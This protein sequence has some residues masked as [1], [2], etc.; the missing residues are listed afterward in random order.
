MHPE[1]LHSAG[2]VDPSDAIRVRK[3]DPFR[4]AA[5]PPRAYPWPT[6]GVVAA[7]LIWPALWNGYPLV[8]ADS[9]TYLGQA[10]LVYASWDRPPFYSLFLYALHWRLSLWPAVVGQGVLLAHL[11]FL[12]F[13]VEGQAASLQLAAAAVALATLTG[14]PFIAAQLQPDLFTGCVVL[15]TWLLGFRYSALSLNERVYLLMLATFSIVVHQ[16]H[17]PLAFGLI[18][19][20]LPLRGA[21]E[22]LREAMQS[23]GRMLAPP[24]LAILGLIA[25]NTAAHKVPM[26]SPYGSVFLATRLLFDPAGANYLARHCPEAS[27]RVCDVRGAMGQGHNDF[28]WDLN[29]PLYTHLGGPKGWAAEASNLVRAI[30]ADDPLGVARD[31]WRNTLSQLAHANT[32]EGLG[33]WPAAPGPEPLIHRFFPGE[34]GAFREAK[35]QRGEL[36]P[37][38]RR[39]APFHVVV[40][41]AGLP[42]LLGAATWRRLSPQRF[43]LVALI[44]AATLGN[45]VIAGALSGPS[46]RYQARI[47]WLVT[48][49]F[50]I[51]VPVRSVR[52]LVA[53]RVGGTGLA[54]GLAGRRA[55]LMPEVAQQ[56]VVGVSSEG[57]LA[58]DVGRKP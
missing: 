2:A 47:L 51:V 37:L 11:I 13:R 9:G 40:F 20:A 54:S 42:V 26:L 57:A 16:S 3:K 27:F 39:L 55:G 46:D 45:A 8:F 43:A 15:A 23:V 32:G 56:V 34:H 1:F 52:G 58:R 5:T 6:L 28:L 22:G 35:Q 33:P 4:F 24:L 49:A 14:L 44:I 36:E 38:V 25:I 48:V 17:I 31:A 7:L 10:L 30:V 41:C 50:F 19:V 53:T 12:I 18:M 21:T 29:G